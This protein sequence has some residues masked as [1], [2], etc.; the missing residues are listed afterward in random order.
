MGGL[1][2]RYFAENCVVA[3]RA[4]HP[5]LA[6]PPG[7]L[8]AR[9]DS[10]ARAQLRRAGGGGGRRAR[11]AGQDH[12][13]AV[14]QQAGHHGRRHLLAAALGRRG[15]GRGAGHLPG[16]ARHRRRDHRRGPHRQ[17]APRSRGGAAGQGRGRIV[18][19]L[20][21]GRVRL[22]VLAVEARGAAH[23]GQD[24][25]RDQPRLHR[26]RRVHREPA[27]RVCTPSRTSCSNR[28]WTSTA[29]RSGSRPTG[30]PTCS[31]CAVAPPAA[32]S[33]SEERIAAI[34]DALVSA[35]P[36]SRREPRAAVG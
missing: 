5:G 17:R 1:P 13:R 3:D 31:T 7:Q 29:R 10:A 9:G 20:A 21:H 23:R 14:R 28:A 34:R 36:G 22:D 16:A 11:L 27:R 25:Q 15:Q 19:L 24:R 4:P 33:S 18:G 35:L 30:S 2:D 8:R 32:R 26:G 12:R 6:R